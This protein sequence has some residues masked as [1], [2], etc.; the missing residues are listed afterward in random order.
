M[1]W[2]MSGFWAID[3]RVTCG[4]RSYTKPRR[5]SPVTGG[6]GLGGAWPVRS[7][8]LRTP[9]SEAA[10]RYHGY[11]AAISLERARASATRLVSIVIQRLPQ[12]SA[13]YAV[14]PEPHVGSRT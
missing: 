2:R 9:A 8:S 3:L 5:T 11:L 13:T 4:T 12:C 6:I 10:R 7:A 14:V 1:P